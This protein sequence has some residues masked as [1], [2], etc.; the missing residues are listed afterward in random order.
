MNKKIQL[1]NELARTKGSGK[2]GYLVV[3]KNK[4]TNGVKREPEK[5]NYEDAIK[6]AKEL[7]TSMPDYDVKVFSYTD[8]LAKVPSDTEIVRKK[9]RPAKVQTFKAPE[10][11]KQK[12]QKKEIPI[13]D[14][15][16]EIK[17]EVPKEE[18][19]KE[20]PTSHKYTGELTHDPEK[21]HWGM[22]FDIFGKIYPKYDV[23]KFIVKDPDRNKSGKIIRADGKDIKSSNFI[24]VMFKDGEERDY[25]REHGDF[26][27]LFIS[28]G[29]RVNVENIT[30]KNLIK[31]VKEESIT[32][33]G[34]I[35]LIKKL[36][37]GVFSA[38]M[39][40]PF[41]WL[42]ISE[43]EQFE[44]AREW[45]DPIS[46]KAGHETGWKILSLNDI[47]GRPSMDVIIVH[48][49]NMAFN[50]F[51]GPKAKLLAQAFALEHSDHIHTE[52]DEKSDVEKKEKDK[53]ILLKGDESDSDK[54]PIGSA[55]DS[56]A[57]KMNFKDN[58]RNK[59]E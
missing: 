27:K 9:G 50:T 7:E 10:A 40:S 45:G 19:W 16:T 12:S 20:L 26:K 38:E 46:D 33:T 4:K 22:R 23:T 44:L 41:P 34:K 57:R 25:S 39:K 56:T 58:K 28:G 29:P 48:E 2:S 11:L 55:Y 30:K 59:G 43:T 13:S 47:K 53:K 18:E 52:E 6:K 51:S 15:Q 31:I 1:L 5:F 35:F 32:T 17:P 49:N 21:W 24:T 8:S 14:K 42:P 54:L 37:E 36:L 3:L